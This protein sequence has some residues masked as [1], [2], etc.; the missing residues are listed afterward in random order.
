LEKSGQSGWCAIHA[1]TNNH[2]TGRPW[3]AFFASWRLLGTY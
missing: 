1:A 3:F 2:R